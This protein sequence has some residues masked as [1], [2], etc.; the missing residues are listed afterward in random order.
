MVVAVIAVVTVQELAVEAVDEDALMVVL[1]V[2]YLLVINSKWK[3]SEQVAVNGNQAS[4]RI[5]PSSSPRIV[6][7]LV[8]TAISWERTRKRECPGR[9]L[10]KPLTMCLTMRTR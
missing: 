6:N 8:N 3:R 1:A 7:W 5:S 2:L 4:P 9:L 10:S